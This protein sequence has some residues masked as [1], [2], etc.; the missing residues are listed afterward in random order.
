MSMLMSTSTRT[1]VICQPGY[2][3]QGWCHR[4]VVWSLLPLDFFVQ[5]QVEFMQQRLQQREQFRARLSDRQPDPAGTHPAG[6]AAAGG[7]GSP[8]APATSGGRLGDVK[9]SRLAPTML[10]RPPLAA[11]ESRSSSTSASCGA[12]KDRHS[13]PGSSSIVFVTESAM[14]VTMS[15]AVRRAAVIS[16]VQLNELA[17]RVQ[18]SGSAGAI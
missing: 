11:S 2:R 14:P 1:R 13:S 10:T 6:G 3:I 9:S 15:G 8:G 12:G 18:L 17:Q 4:R 16:G 7:P 5:H